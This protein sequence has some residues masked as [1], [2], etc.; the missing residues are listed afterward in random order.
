MPR[1]GHHH[2][3]TPA[4]DRFRP[5]DAVVTAPFL[6]VAVLFP[7]LAL[8]GIVRFWHPLPWWDMWDGDLG[9]WYQLTGGDLGAWWAQ[10][11]EHRI[12]L[13]RVIFW[14]DLA[15]FRGSGWI[16][17]VANVLAVAGIATT[18]VTA[19]RLRLR[20]ARNGLDPVF[21]SVA[22]AAVLVVLSTSWLQHENLDW[23]F[24]VQ[25]LLAVLL[26]LMALLL[27]AHARPLPG[28]SGPGSRRRFAAGCLLA[29]ASIGTIASGL[30]VP[31]AAAVVAAVGGA[32]R[33]R[34]LLLGVVGAACLGV[35]FYGYVSPTGH[36]SPLVAI[37]HPLALVTY[38]VRYL[39]APA[40]LL[41]NRPG[42]ATLAGGAFLLVTPLA[43]WYAWRSRDRSPTGIAMA[44]FVAF[45][46]GTG[47]LTALGRV[48]FGTGQATMSRYETP[49]LAGWA[50]LLILVAPPVERM[51]A[52]RARPAGVL[53]LLAIPLAL[54]PFQLQA[55]D[56]TA[57]LR[58]GRDAAALAIALGVPDAAVIVSVFPN[59]EVPIALGQRAMGDGLTILAQPPYRDLA[60]QLG[61]RPPALPAASCRGAIEATVAQ[62]GGWTRITGWATPAGQLGTRSA[63]L[64]VVDG[65]GAVVGYVATGRL[66]S[67]REATATGD[68]HPGFMGYMRTGAATG[69]LR[70][71]GTVGACVD[72]LAVG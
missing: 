9:F 21:G 49:V 20:E 55:L 67:A 61:T 70:L 60:G 7:L 5:V 34:V 58:F 50:S 56:D 6:I 14:I 15:A 28:S 23:G 69:P 47:L 11:N 26:P 30:L 64:D 42:A 68:L 46:V 65:S 37:S 24:Q 48:D 72:P 38:L 27:V 33:R 71:A 16:L 63:L 1:I 22:M 18:L 51:L 52:G 54:A 19:L 3:V 66:R 39:G 57:P 62:P 32:Q 59:T 12:V 17:I 25:F 10:H 36:A 31:F 13:A 8:I 35:Y 45:V 41:T 40:N 4:R 29:V 2:G 44:G 43:C 53:V